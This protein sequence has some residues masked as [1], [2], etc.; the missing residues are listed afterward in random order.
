MQN[1]KFNTSSKQ[2]KK[3][4]KVIIPYNQKTPL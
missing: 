4:E 2:I 3:P 1:C